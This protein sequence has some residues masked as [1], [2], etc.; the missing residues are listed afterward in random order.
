MTKTFKHFIFIFC[1]GLSITHLRSQTP[2]DALLMD[3]NQLCIAPMYTHESWKEYWEGTLLRDN[4]NIGIF[5]KQ[6]INP[7]LAYGITDKISVL[8]SL[9]YV[10]TKDSRG[11]LQGVSGIQDLS[12]FLKAKLLN[13]KNSSH[14]FG[15]FL[16]AGFGTPISNYLSDYQPY[17]IGLG[18]QEFSLRAIVKYE[19][20]T[21]TY[22]RLGAGYYHRTDTKVERD[23]HYNNGSVYSEYMD[24]PNAMQY[25]VTLGQWVANNS[26]QIEVG[27]HIQ[28][29]NSGD[30]IR[31]Q[32]PGQPT[33]KVNFTNGSISLRYFP[34]FLNGVSIIGSYAQNFA[35]RNIGKTQA[36]TGT[37]TYQFYLKKK[38]NS[39]TAN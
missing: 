36:L 11:Q 17:A 31:R 9:P 20:K 24:V 39:E 1:I 30:D 18:T 29:S 23:Y 16:T 4:L 33:N 8:L 13:F 6:S 3:K 22:L 27:T 19:Y 37:I 21:Q 12:L 34:A 32:N 25:E 7:M 38:N 35:G 5:T 28:S 2:T 10:T 26:L 14:D 15:G